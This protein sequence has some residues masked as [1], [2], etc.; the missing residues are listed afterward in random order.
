MIK[1]VLPMSAIAAYETQ[2]QDLSDE[3]EQ[4]R[5]EIN[6]IVEKFGQGESLPYHA[7]TVVGVFGSGKT[8]LLYHI[9]HQCLQQDILPIYFEADRL[10]KT[11][12]ELD[13]PGPGD[14]T[15]II[16]KKVS[17]LEEAIAQNNS[18]TVHEL[19]NPGDDT[20]KEQL[21]NSILDAFGGESIDEKAIL[22]DELEQQ[23]ESLQEHVR[24]DENSP[25]R[26]WLER[27]NELKFLALAP[28]GMYEMGGADRTRCGRIV[29]PPVDINHLRD[30]YFE[31]DAGL[32]NACWWLS[33]GNP[34]HILSNANELEGRGDI[35]ESPPHQIASFLNGL[36]PIGQEPSVVPAANLDEIHR[37]RLE[38]LLDLAPQ[39]SEEQRRYVIDVEEADKAE[40][41]ELAADIFEVD[42]TV[43]DYLS[44]Y[45]FLVASTLSDGEN[46]CYVD[47][48][49][50]L[51]AL[52][53]DFLLEYQHNNPEI[54][55]G[56]REVTEAYNQLDSNEIDAT[57][58]RLFEYKTASKALPFST[59]EI[60]EVFRLPI[61]DPVV[62]NHAVPEIREAHEGN[63]RPLWKIN[64]PNRTVYFFISHR[65]LES[66][67]QTDEFLDAALPDGNTVLCITADSPGSIE[68]E[69]EQ[70]LQNNGKLDIETSSPLLSDFLISLVGELN[71]TPPANLEETLNELAD[72]DDPILERKVNIY[73]ESFERLIIGTI[74][75]P[76]TFCEQD[77]PYTHIWGR[78]QI[79]NRE[80]V[81]PA[82]AQAYREETGDKDIELLA[83]LG[84][85]FESG[86]HLNFIATGKAGYVTVAKDLLPLHGREY[87]HQQ[88][89]KNLRRYFNNESEL[90]TLAQ[91]VSEE[92]FRKLSENEN[93]DRLLTAFWRATRAEFDANNIQ[94]NNNWIERELIDRLES[95]EELASNLAS[96]RHDVTVNFDSQQ[97]DESYESYMA[98]Q[99]AEAFE[100]LFQ[101]TDSCINDSDVL[102]QK[103]YSM[104]LT[105]VRDHEQTVRQFGGLVDHAQD[106]ADDFED[107][108]EN[109][110]KNLWEYSKAR[111]FVEITEE[112]IDSVIEENSLSGRISIDDL[113]D[114][115]ERARQ[116]IRKCIRD[117]SSIEENL[118]DLQE[119]LE[120]IAAINPEYEV[121]ET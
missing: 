85:L 34:R 107:A 113:A 76:T 110:E 118:V 89:I 102:V 121:E 35:R 60:R 41:I 59:D 6:E 73:R 26:D 61:V 51:F 57:I 16:S 80:A 84:A 119:V 44:R 97:S 91:L 29:I 88:V 18:E 1:I 17:E 115:L 65:D 30:E 68:G 108:A 78:D 79:G 31:N 8:Q 120:K 2:W 47:E 64:R 92:T 95:A 15:D 111:E 86:G 14:I 3:H 19:L 75:S 22:V 10:F 90:R 42:R 45:F 71:E 74:S 49:S 72:S 25:L 82:V 32:A 7:Y 50:G 40:F 38:D 100:K 58:G 96:G 54:K 20:D 5:E 52:A 39:D 55:E 116:G 106:E 13:S 9:H 81:I 109:L 117:M 87:E 114:E 11:V 69:F 98:A 99:N 105:A 48:L 24:A 104:Y 62:K 43:A 46:V 77:V 103:L 37:G 67:A 66:Y 12:F 33:R 70:W 23:Y 63:G 93:K 21:V 36:D 56:I 4:T 112:E 28:A 83:E 27:G 94:E 53:I 101:L